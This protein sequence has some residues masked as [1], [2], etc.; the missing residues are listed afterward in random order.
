M[1][2]SLIPIVLT[3]KVTSDH[4]TKQCKLH[5]WDI[6]FYYNSPVSRNL[7]PEIQVRESWTEPKVWSKLFLFRNY[8][9]SKDAYFFHTFDSLWSFF[10]GRPQC[11]CAILIATNPA[12]TNTWLFYQMVS[13][14]SFQQ[15]KKLKRIKRFIRK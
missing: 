4:N 6:H 15:L 11:A 9:Q 12:Q 14:R 13:P 3:T 1:I 10:Y 5:L 7:S 2:T 8:H